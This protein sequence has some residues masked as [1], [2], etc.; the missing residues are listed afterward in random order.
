[1]PKTKATDKTKPD[2]K[3]PRPAP[4]GPKVPN[5]ATREAIEEI[6]QGKGTV[7]ES[8]EALFRKL[9]S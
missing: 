1:M 5:A 6:E 4:A 8:V 9:G 3:A 2:E 7:H